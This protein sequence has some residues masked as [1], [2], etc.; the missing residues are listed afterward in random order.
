MK[1]AWKL[2]PSLFKDQLKLLGG[3]PG[4]LG[5]ERY[6]DAV[7]S[8]F[9]GLMR[10][11]LGIVSYEETEST[12]IDASTKLH[13]KDYTTNDNAI[14]IRY[15]VMCFYR[16]QGKKVQ[17]Q[18]LLAKE[19]SKKSN[20]SPERP[21]TETSVINPFSRVRRED[22]P[23]FFG[24]LAVQEGA[25]SSATSDLLDKKRRLDFV[26]HGRSVK[27]QG[28]KGT[29]TLPDIPVPGVSNTK[30][31]LEDDPG[32]FQTADPEKV[33]HLGPVLVIVPEDGA[34]DYVLVELSPFDVYYREKLRVDNHSMTYLSLLPTFDEMK[35]QGFTFHFYSAKKDYVSHSF[36]ILRGLSNPTVASVIMDSSIPEFHDFK[37]LF[38]FLGRHGEH[39]PSRDA[40]NKTGKGYRIDLGACDHSFSG[41][42]LTGL[43]PTPKTNGGFKYFEKTG[44]AEEDARL[45][46]LLAY[47][48]SMTDAVQLIVD[49]ARHKFGFK[50]IFD[51]I[52]REEAFAVPFRK[53]LGAVTSRAEEGSYFATALDGTDGCS[54]HIDASN[55]PMDTY[56]FTCCAGTIVESKSTGRL[57]RWVNNLNSRA[58]CGR[59]MA[60]ETKHAPFNKRLKSEMERIDASYKEVYGVGRN[61]PTATTFTNLYLTDS[62]SWGDEKKI[63]MASAPSRDFFLSTAASA[64]CNLRQAG[65]LGCHTT[66]GLL[67]IALYMSSYEQL[68]T[69]MLTIEKDPT[70]LERIKTDQ[71]GAYWVTSVDIFEKFWGGSPARFSPSGFDFKATFVEDKPRFEDAV[72]Q[73]KELLKLVNT[74]SKTEAVAV[75]KKIKEMANSPKLPY[76][77]VF[78]LQL[79]IPLAALCRLVLTDHL[80]HA[81]YIEPSESVNNGSHSALMNAGFPRNRH[82]DTLLNICG[83]VGLPRRLS[84]GEGLACESHRHQKRFDLFI[85]GQDLFHLFLNDKGYKVQLKRFNSKTWEPMLVIDLDVMRSEDCA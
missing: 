18:K 2:N 60:S 40:G 34:I 48:G 6:E 47:F 64:I 57:Y 33:E 26:S 35:E 46:E 29:N 42:N 71:P 65:G 31:A 38:E 7:R 27:P 10:T 79:F 72:V 77:N 68:H 55:C 25:Q 36:A 84:L 24:L 59:A 67:L 41:E 45:P 74:S 19:R 17:V 4:V 56:D 75:T 11:V 70:L 63:V 53:L 83:Q 23:G 52:L 28:E 81:D 8:D 85:H 16:I 15:R 30:M 3:K 44:D 66:V 22:T 43:G 82:S 49:K 76:L 21:P 5:M 9:D 13:G 20:E 37:A 73:L 54:F 50:R 51:D 62:L 12:N 80:F 69:I 78:R 14:L 58:A 32:P 39:Q 61:E 1:Q